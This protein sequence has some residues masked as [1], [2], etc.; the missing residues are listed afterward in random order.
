MI[1]VNNFALNNEEIKNNKIVKDKYINILLNFLSLNE[2]EFSDF[3]MQLIN[4]NF[5]IKNDKYINYSNNV[6]FKHS[7]KQTLFNLIYNNTILNIVNYLGKDN[8][9]FIDRLNFMREHEKNTINYEIMDAIMNKLNALE[10]KIEK[11]RE[12]TPQ[13]K[14]ELRSYDSYP[15]NQ[16]LSQFFDD[17]QEEMEKTGKNDYVLTSDD[18]TDINV[19]DIKGSFQGNGFKDEY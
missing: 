8:K 15:F 4:K 14:L 5:F 19:N 3:D 7:E 2:N 12:K 6:I 9:F 11:Y 10:N 18:V 17:K 13:E 16:K 1:R